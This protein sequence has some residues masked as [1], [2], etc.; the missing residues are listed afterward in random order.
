VLQLCLAVKQLGKGGGG[1]HGLD[2]RPGKYSGPYRGNAAYPYI[3]SLAPSIQA[4]LWA[5]G[6]LVRRNG[7]GSRAAVDAREGVD[8]LGRSG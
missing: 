7:M 2:E 8:G 4:S 1:S 6:E 5:R 3:E